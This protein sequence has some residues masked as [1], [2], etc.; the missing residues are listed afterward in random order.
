MSHM[1]VS[2]SQDSIG[3]AS[4]TVEERSG[5]EGGGR[6]GGIKPGY[7]DGKVP[8]RGARSE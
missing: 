2:L 8:S 4:K 6:E 7:N 3:N 5:K 1:H